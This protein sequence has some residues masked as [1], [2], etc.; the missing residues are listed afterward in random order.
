MKRFLV[1]WQD[2]PSS[3]GIKLAIILLPLSVFYFLFTSHRLPPE[4]PLFYSRP[5]GEEQLTPSTSLLMLPLGGLLF[6]FLNIGMAVFL[7]DEFPFL[8]R[9]LVWSTA[10]ISTLACIALFKIITLIT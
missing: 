7:F 3:L 1:L 9:I 5:W 2:K 10:L 4:V 8:A 6:T